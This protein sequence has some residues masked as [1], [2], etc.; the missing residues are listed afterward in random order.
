MREEEIRIFL[1]GG[2]TGGH[3]MPLVFVARELKKIAEERK[4]PLKIFYLGVQPFNEKILVDEEIKVIKIPSSKLRKYF[5]FKNFIDILKFPL[6]FLCALFYLFKYMPN[7]I[8]SKGG[9]GSLGVVLAGWILR[10]PI[11]IHESDSIPGLTNKISGFFAKKIYLAFESAKKFFDPEKTEV[12]GQ[13]INTYLIQ[14]PVLIEDYKR[15]GLDPYK[16]IILVLGG[17]Q[18]SKFLNDLIVESLPELLDIAQVVHQ[19]GEKN[20]QD[21]YFYAKAVLK[22]QEDKLNNYHIFPFLKNEDLIFLMK[23]ADLIIARAGAGTIFEISALGKPSILIP[24]DKKV[25]GDHQIINA[26]IYAHAG[27]AKMIEEENAKPHILITLIKELF[28]NPSLLED[29]H[30]K[31]LSF[32]KI[33]AGQKIAIDIIL[34]V[35]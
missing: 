22:N 25:A 23:I 16:K 35:E 9:P 5:S 19:T 26:K 30:K 18:G 28:H 20:Y 34:A 27:A 21:T 24:I 7:L 1:T 6:N 11:F 3:L 15:F 17:S 13:P 14:Q 32:A 8:F 2:A 12:V 4:L 29:M 33:N 10:I 31:A